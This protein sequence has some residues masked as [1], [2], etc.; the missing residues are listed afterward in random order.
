MGGPVS[1]DDAAKDVSGEMCPGE[2]VMFRHS[3][4]E[5]TSTDEAEST[6]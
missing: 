5:S 3:A 2:G 6:G 4:T 1:W